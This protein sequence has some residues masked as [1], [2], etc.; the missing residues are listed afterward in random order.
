MS[1]SQACSLIS[2]QR[3]VRISVASSKHT[4]SRMH[5]IARSVFELD[6]VLHAPIEGDTHNLTFFFLV[7]TK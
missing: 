6:V 3:L 2:Q 7:Y 4:D 1:C 5:S